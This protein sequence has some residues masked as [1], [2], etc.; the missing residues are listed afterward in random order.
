MA[1][2]MAEWIDVAAIEI[3]FQLREDKGFSPLIPKHLT[4]MNDFRTAL[5]LL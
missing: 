1:F 5:E 4:L 3:S 2:S